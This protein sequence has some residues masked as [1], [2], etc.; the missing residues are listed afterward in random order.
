MSLRKIL[1]PGLFLAFFAMYPTASPLASVNCFAPSGPEQSHDEISKILFSRESELRRTQQKNRSQCLIDVVRLDKL[2]RDHKYIDVSKGSSRAAI[3]MDDMLAIPLNQ[4]KLKRYLQ[5]QHLVLV[6]HGF[7]LHEA[8]LECGNLRNQ[9]YKH[10]Y[11]LKDGHLA[12]AQKSKKIKASVE[13]R[14]AGPRQLFTERNERNWIIVHNEDLNLQVLK[15]YLPES[16]LYITTRNLPKTLATV[17]NTSLPAGIMIVDQK[18][19]DLQ[20]FTIIANKTG[21]SDV[22]YLQSGVEGFENYINKQ[23]LLTSKREFVLQKP[24]SCAR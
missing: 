7:D 5:N 10:V 9:G 2:P 12:L 11:V 14:L 19:T 15:R 22:F 16:T 20:N 4:I 1:T 3:L 18:G 23:Y 8:L 24:Q 13:H 21:R 17:S 6:T